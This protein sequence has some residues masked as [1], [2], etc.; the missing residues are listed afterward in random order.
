MKKEKLTKEDIAWRKGFED[1]AK[2]MTRQND[3]ALRI[4]NAILAALDERY[5]HKEEDY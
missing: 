5:E 2:E 1:G 4:G 3:I